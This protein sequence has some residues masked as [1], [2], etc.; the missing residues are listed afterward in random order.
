MNLAGWQWLL[1][2][3]GIP[4]ILVGFW[5]IYYLDSTIEEAKSVAAR[6]VILLLSHPYL[7]SCRQLLRSAEQPRHT[8]TPLLPTIEFP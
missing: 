1:L 2:T 3:E 8:Y 6:F 4:T 5:V 7:H